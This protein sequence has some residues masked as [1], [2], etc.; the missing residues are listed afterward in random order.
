MKIIVFAA[1]LLSVFFA[2]IPAHSCAGSKAAENRASDNG[3]QSTPGHP[4]SKSVTNL[5][6]INPVNNLLTAEKRVMEHAD[7]TIAVAR[8]IIEGLMQGPRSKLARS[9]PKDSE[10]RT[11]FTD[12]QKTAYV[13]L[14]MNSARFPGGCYTEFLS[15]YSIVNSLVLNLPEVDSV[16]ILI[17]GKDVNTLAGHID[18]RKPFEANMLIVR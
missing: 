6:F 12:Q 13:D 15:I 1:I 8:L 14:K 7:S 4:N 16:K 17:N 9:L 18:A 11:V 10:L 5:Y 3:N 2:L